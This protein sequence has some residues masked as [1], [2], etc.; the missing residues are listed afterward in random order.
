MLNIQTQTLGR[1]TGQ[2][3]RVRPGGR[4]Y[5]QQTRLRKP[6]AGAAERGGRYAGGPGRRPQPL[7]RLSDPD[8]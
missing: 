1:Y 8:T 3:C 7:R 5:G 2:R 6:G 4:S